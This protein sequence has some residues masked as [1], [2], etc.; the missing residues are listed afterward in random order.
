MFG[1]H[2]YGGRNAYNN[3]LKLEFTN[4]IFDNTQANI[5]CWFWGNKS[6][7]AELPDTFPTTGSH[8]MILSGNSYYQNAGSN[9]GGQVNY[10]GKT[11][12]P[13]YASSQKA[14]EDAVRVLDPDAANAGRVT[15]LQQ[16]LTD[17]AEQGDNEM[18]YKNITVNGANISDYVIVNET[19]T[20]FG[21]LSVNSAIKAVT[22]KYLAVA[23]TAPANGKAVRIITNTA[24]APNTVKVYVNNGT[25]YIAA[26]DT[27]FVD[28]AISV[29]KGILEDGKVTFA[30]GYEKTI[31]LSSYTY[32]GKSGLRLIGDSDKNPVSYNVG[33][34]ATINLGAYSSGSNQIVSVPQFKVTVY[35]E[36]TGKTTTSTYTGTD[37]VCSFTVTSNTA[38]FVYWTVV[39]C[40][41]NG[42]KISGFTEVDS[43]VHYSG[44][45]GFGVK[46]IAKS[47]TK[48][49]DFDSNWAA[50]ASEV[51]STSATAT[52]M[53]SVS[54]NSGYEAYRVVIPYDNAGGFV[55]GYL[56]YPKNASASSLGLM[57]RFQGNSVAAPDK[58]YD[59]NAAVFTV[60]AH[61][62]DLTKT[63]DSTYMDSFKSSINKNGNNFAWDNSTFDTSYLVKMVKRDLLA[64]KFMIEHFTEKG[65]WNGTSFTAMGTSMGG[66][67]S[68]AVAALLDDVTG[69]KVTTLNVSL[70]WLCDLGAETS[71]NNRKDSTWRPTYAYADTVH[72]ATML[73]N[74]DQ[75]IVNAGLGDVICPASGIM[76]F[77]NT[78]SNSNKSITFR[79]NNTHGGGYDG[80]YY[81]IV[82]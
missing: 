14:F 70:P 8:Y 6:N 58:N 49:S 40:D 43:G 77:Y 74:V 16:W 20:E 60:C 32:S 76:A 2:I 67:Q 17:L 71:G 34:T 54:A 39:A 3:Q 66:F 21:T 24:L 15:Y 52:T 50:A 63:G 79:Q 57:V 45:V 75:I 46:S 42:N 10:Y 37:G 44:S 25:L 68:I 69:K 80:A 33:E 1:C 55:T 78:I 81:S 31:T 4:N 59:A 19:S 64:S 62:L 7:A 47:S 56:T 48:P 53:E 61:S 5:F 65:L 36:A 23:E 27:L 35:S 26:H 72:F 82:G 41:S 73:G 13:A 9:S 11:T 30:N 12:D 29:F 28:D 38:G 22:G 51:A 18:V